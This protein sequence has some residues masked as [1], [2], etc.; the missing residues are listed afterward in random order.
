M[1]ST[2]SSTRQTQAPTST[3]SPFYHRRKPSAM[4]LSDAQS[5]CPVYLTRLPVKL[6]VLHTEIGVAL[7]TFGSLFMFLGI[8]LLFDAAL[9]AL[10]NVGVSSQQP[11]PALTF[12]LRCCSSLASHSSLDPRRRFTFLLASKS[13]VE[14]YASSV[15][16]CSSF[17]NTHS[18]G[19]S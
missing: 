18:L 5:R 12:H 4:W 2:N 15:A 13:Y 9:L 11:V 8:M 1:S 16:F 19:W 10:G 14:R 7:T 6:T 3:N 17:S